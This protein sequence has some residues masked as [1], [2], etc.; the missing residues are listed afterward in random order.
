MFTL[1]QLQ[2]E[3]RAWKAHN[4]PDSANHYPL[5]GMTEELG[6]L[7]EAK[8]CADH[9]D[10]VGDTIVYIADYCNVK[11]WNLQTLW[12][13][14]SLP[15]SMH[16]L[17]PGECCLICLGKIHHHALK[18]AQQIRGTADEHNHQGQIW[19]SRLLATLDEHTDSLLHEVE[20]TWNKVKQR[21]WQKNR[22]TGT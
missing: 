3:H 1:K 11:G 9:G 4:F 21:D 5:L 6:E 14:R 13:C 12:D 10:A 15:D 19:L 8:T 18:G 17:L 7:M 2:E 20:R 16:E 22:V